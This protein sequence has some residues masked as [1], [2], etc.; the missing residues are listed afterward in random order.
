MVKIRF[1]R[2]LVLFL[3]LNSKLATRSAFAG[4]LE[5]RHWGDFSGGLWSAGEP[6]GSPLVRGHP[7]LWDRE[8]SIEIFW[9]EPMGL[10]WTRL[11]RA[12]EP[13]QTYSR[14]AANALPLPS[15]RVRPWADQDIC[16]GLSGHGSFDIHDFQN[17]DLWIGGRE[18]GRSRY[19]H[20]WR[21]SLWEGSLEFPLDE[22][23][24]MARFAFKSASSLRKFDFELLAADGSSAWRIQETG[25]WTGESSQ[26]GVFG[27]ADSWHWALDY[28]T[29]M[30][31]E[32]SDHEVIYQ[33]TQNAFASGNME[34]ASTVLM[35]P[36]WSLAVV[37]PESEGTFFWFEASVAQWSRFRADGNPAELAGSG[38]FWDTA[39]FQVNAQGQKEI[40]FPSYHDA[41]SLGFGAQTEINKRINL[42]WSS[43]FQAHYGNLRVVEPMLAVGATWRAIAPFAL[44]AGLGLSRRDYFGDNAFWPADQR[45]D[46]IRLILKVGLRYSFGGFFE[47]R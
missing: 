9:S 46:E 43:R 23:N 14:W 30:P 33:S 3:T 19:S 22:N 42:K 45:L 20:D 26:I 35:P 11:I 12:D 39:L 47:M 5:S 24:L 40:I 27:R 4:Y 7:L 18:D 34:M 6:W 28:Q 36:I 44:D 1:L 29:P 32:S 37:S 10:E 8:R 38:L 17:R 16:F 13:Y 31:I 2:L 41:L 15:L 21:M 25:H